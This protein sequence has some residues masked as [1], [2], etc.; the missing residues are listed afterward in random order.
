MYYYYYYVQLMYESYLKET[1]VL[2]D[3]FRNKNQ[4]P[5]PTSDH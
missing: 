5:I 3:A 1:K 4:T 2:V